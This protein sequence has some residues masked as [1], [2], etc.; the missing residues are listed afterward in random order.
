MS[1]V[2][3][4]AP[5]IPNPGF[6]DPTREAQSAFRAILDAL[7]HPTRSYP[8]A[9]PATPPAAFGP[10][11]GAVALTVLDEDCTVWLGGALA[12]DAELAAWLD[13]H[14]G[15]RRVAEPASAD[16]AFA[17]PGE[18]PAFG[19]F[20]LGT[21][22]APHL[23][24]TLVI[25][26]RGIV[27]ASPAEVHHFIARGPGIDGEAELDAPWADRIDD[28][29]GQWKRNAGL[30][31]RGVDLLLVG[32]DEVTA[33]PRTTRLA[34]V[35]I[36]AARESTSG[37]ASRESTSGGASRESTSGAGEANEEG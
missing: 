13:F 11:L 8:L 34:G 14:T 28:F 10:G 18:L 36:H 6:A 26:V 20:R 23:S 27:C 19:A 29:S 21:D 33:L 16:F 35:S 1:A 9:G 7:A 22:E 37:G 12:E 32:E 30:F 15:A 31:P 5:A 24:T 2:A 3:G 4:Q 17:A 25:D